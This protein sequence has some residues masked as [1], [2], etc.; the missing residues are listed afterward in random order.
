MIC[1]QILCLLKK[2]GGGIFLVERTL[3]LKIM[4]RLIKK[5]GLL[6]FGRKMKNEIAK[7]LIVDQL[8][9]T[10]VIFQLRSPN[11]GFNTALTAL[12]VCPIG[13]AFF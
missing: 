7:F 11:H 9:A 10:L 2:R 3:Q 8:G 6:Y 12:I 1:P 13:L 5:I 4:I